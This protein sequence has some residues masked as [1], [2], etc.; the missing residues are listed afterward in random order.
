MS[1]EMIYLDDLPFNLTKDESDYLLSI[2]PEDIAYTGM[3]WGFSDTV[4]RDEL[5]VY[6]IKE[7]LK[8]PSTKEYYESDIFKELRE[9]GTILS[10]EILFGK[11]EKFTIYFSLIFFGIDGKDL[12]NTGNMVITAANADK[13]KKNSFFAVAT[14]MFKSGYVLKSLEITK[15]E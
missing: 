7:K 14:S 9:K 4:F 8:F 5:F 2:I 11:T 6:I 15:I 1:D 3:Q 12:P 13:A 10:N